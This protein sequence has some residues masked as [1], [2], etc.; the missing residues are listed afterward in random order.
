MTPC[1]IDA[2]VLLKLFLAEEDSAAVTRIV[3]A[4]LQTDDPLLAVP[5]L[6]YVECANVLWSKVRAGRYARE[7][8]QRA[9]T[10]LRALALATTPTAELLDAALALA[11][12]YDITV[13]DACYVALAARLAQPLLT[14][15]AK[16]KS[17]LPGAPYAIVLVPEFLTT[18]PA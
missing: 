14:A 15:D 6:V 7:A 4:H 12:R 9:V 16:L 1:V 8:A 5:D 18:Y 17:R 11:C 3:G 2:S 13:Y 10:H